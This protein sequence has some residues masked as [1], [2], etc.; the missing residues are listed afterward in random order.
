MNTQLIQKKEED[1]LQMLNLPIKLKFCLY[2]S[3]YCNQKVN[4]NQSAGSWKESSKSYAIYL[5]LN[6]KHCF[7]FR[8]FPRKT[9]ENI[10]QKK[11]PKTLFWGP[12][13]SLFAQIWAKMTF[14]KKKG[15]VSF[16]IFQLS[17]IVPKIRKNYQPKGEF[18]SICW[19]LKKSSKY[20]IYLLLNKKHC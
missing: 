9:N 11:P 3:F 20:V 18:K 19:Q 4:L 5:L 16:K 17:K 12:F 8:L 13:W 2:F 15:S 6:K 7:Q 14:P 1:E 10:F